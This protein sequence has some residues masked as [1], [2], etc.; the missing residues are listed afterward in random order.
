[1]NLGP[2]IAVDVDD[3]LL[4]FG[5]RV[6]QTVNKEYDAKLTSADITSWNLNELLDPILGED[7]WAWWEERDWLW[8]KADAIDGA[9]GALRVLHQKGYRIELVTAK[10]DWA[11]KGLNLWLSRWNPWYDALIIGPARPAMNKTWVTN[12]DLLIDDKPDNC[13][14]FTDDGRMAILF[15]RPHNLGFTASSIGARRAGNWRHALMLIDEMMPVD[16]YRKADV[17]A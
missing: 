5:G 1:V 10:P 14:D 9:M 7:W 13:K 16:N 15:T 2:T 8:A 11:R 4:D 3:V 6:I 17:L 12:A